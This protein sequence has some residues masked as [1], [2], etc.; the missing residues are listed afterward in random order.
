MAKRNGFHHTALRVKD[1]DAAVAFYEAL[2]CSVKLIWDNRGSRSCLM[3]IGG[4]NCL[5][6][7]SL[8]KDAEEDAPRF[9]HI[10]L[11]TDDP[12]ADFTAALAAGARP[13][14]EPKD[15][16]LGGDFPARIAFVVGPND[17]VIEFFKE[18]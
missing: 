8:G 15:V 6:I 11:A 7:H 5:E 18:R 14:I 13:R 9:E 16:N 2:G 17:E 12:D 4:N 10:A 1:F 3:D